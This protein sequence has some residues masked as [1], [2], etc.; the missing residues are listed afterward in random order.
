VKKWARTNCIQAPFLTQIV[1]LTIAPAF[2]AAGIY[3]CLSRIVTTF[4]TE[5]SCISPR[6]Y[7]IIFVTFDFLSLVLQSAGGGIASAKT[8]DGEDPKLGN[9]I[10]IAGL[11]TQVATLLI[12]ILL[13]L[14]FAVR[15]IH[16]IRQLG[17]Q[18][19]LDPRHAALRKS[20][21]FKGFLFAL[22]L[23]TLCIFT[24][25]V[26][27]VAELSKGWTGQLIKVQG[28]FIGLEGVVIIAAVYLLNVFHP[29]FCFGESLLPT[30]GGAGTAGKQ[31]FGHKSKDIS[32]ES[33]VQEPKTSDEAIA[34]NGHR[35]AGQV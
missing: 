31:W 16:R 33:S 25:C 22:S 7:P 14:D 3:L 5:N 26:Y 2:L 19:A 1:C 13:A 30:S 35:I 23:S 24:R 32:E 27:R 20:W 4:G 34:H 18:S 11:S 9:N 10:M 12:F 21:V 8:L 6:S 28:Y 29:G 15:T 17:A